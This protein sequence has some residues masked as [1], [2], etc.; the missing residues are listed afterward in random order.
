MHSTP[1]QEIFHN[2]GLI[3]L[4]AAFLGVIFFTFRPGTGLKARDQ[5]QIPFKEDET[6]VR[7]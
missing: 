4:V 7:S 6:N 1:L 2:L 5:A 3:Y